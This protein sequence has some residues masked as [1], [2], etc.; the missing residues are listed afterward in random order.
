MDYYSSIKESL[1]NDLDCHFF[2]SINSTNLFL[3]SQPISKNT[4][5]CVTREQTHGK[6]QHGREWI[7]QKD[8]SILF[9][10]RQ[11][12]N[13]EKNLSGL[14]LIIGLA[15]IKSLEEECIVKGFK[16]K[17]PNDIYFKGKK[18]AGIL[19]ENQIELGY[20][21]VIIGVG[22]NYNLSQNFNCEVP[23]TDLSNLVKK[24]PDI[25]SLT[26]KLINSILIISENFKANGLSSLLEHWDSYDM[27]QG[28]NVRLMESGIYIEGKVTGISQQGALQVLTQNGV[29]ELYSSK[30]I[31]FI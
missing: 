15:I 12:F 1:S 5:V 10:I 2:D 30:Y 19:L 7:S 23:W 24:L 21:F 22:I 29:K 28:S 20:Q 31:E 3:S 25:Q 8:G 13:Q 17:W 16:I 26:A 18:I 27:L 11:N 9:S 4:Q 6:G 14:S